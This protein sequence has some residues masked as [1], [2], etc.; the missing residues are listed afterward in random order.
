MPHPS[1]YITIHVPRFEETFIYRVKPGELQRVRRYFKDLTEGKRAKDFIVFRAVE[2]PVEVAARGREVVFRESPGSAMLSTGPFPL[3]LR[4]Y[5]RDRPE[6]LYSIIHEP[7]DAAWFVTALDTEP[8]PIPLF[9]PA[10]NAHGELIT[11]ASPDIILA[12]VASG[13][14]DDGLRELP[15]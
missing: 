10:T 1:R 12:E 8:M 6:P 14:V 7:S 3:S 4:V 5:M 15:G 11:L 9:W 2:P 13:I